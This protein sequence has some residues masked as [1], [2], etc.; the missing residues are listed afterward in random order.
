MVE[1]GFADPRNSEISL[2]ILRKFSLAQSQFSRED[3]R[4]GELNFITGLIKLKAITEPASWAAVL[5]VLFVC[6]LVK[7]KKMGTYSSILSV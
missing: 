3:T 7:R 6:V 5:F 4:R 2:D 1:E